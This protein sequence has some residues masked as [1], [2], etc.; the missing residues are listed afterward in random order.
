[1]KPSIEVL[2]VSHRSEE[3]PFMGWLLLGPAGCRSYVSGADE[4][5]PS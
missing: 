3:H 4:L 1:M 5:R 2:G